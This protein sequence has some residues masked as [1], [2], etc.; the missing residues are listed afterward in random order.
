MNARSIMPKLDSFHN[1]FLELD[2][3]AA[4]VT[5][6]WLNEAGNAAAR[7]LKDFEDKSDLC[8]IRRDR[9]SGQR[10]G[11]V[12]VV[13]DRRKIAMERAKLPHSKHEVVAAIGR[14]QGQRR[15][16]LI[17]GLYIPPSYNAAQN[18]SLYNYVNDCLLLLHRRYEDPYTIVAGDLN[19]R[20]VGEITR[21][22]HCI[23]PIATPPT[24]GLAVLDIVSS[25]FN[26][27]L[28]EAGVT[29][30]V[31]SDETGADGDHPSGCVHKFQHAQSPP[32]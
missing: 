20:E 21:D 11:G 16:V 15:K 30:P 6:T 18:R 10:G 4:V 13:F 32:V 24:R 1:T 14:R 8:F 27:Q 28:E 5:E 19:R 26:R 25:N 22:F 17:V 2:C 23:R 29:D 3:D 7:K 31:Q 9:N 12:A